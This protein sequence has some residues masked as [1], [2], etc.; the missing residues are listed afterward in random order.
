MPTNLH[1]ITAP[2][3]RNL[4]PPWWFERE[5]KRILSL[6]LQELR[7]PEQIGG[8]KFA[9]DFRAMVKNELAKAFEQGQAIIREASNELKDAVIE[10][11]KGAARVIRQ[12]AQHVRDS[13]GEYTGNNPP[14][15][16]EAKPEP[17][18]I[19]SHLNGGTG[20]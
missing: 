10:Q 5:A 6:V 4:L 2:R 12:E 14:D 11:S 15:D 7:M 13:L 16:E 3:T 9:E 17:D 19:Q 18:P 1:P 8:K 20:T